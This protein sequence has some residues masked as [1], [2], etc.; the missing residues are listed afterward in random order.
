[1]PRITVWKNNITDEI[2]LAQLSDDPIDGSHEDQLA[3]MTT[4]ESYADYT[5]VDN[6]Y[7]GTFPDNDDVSNWRWNETGI[8]Y[9]PPAPIVP[10]FVTPRQV[11]LLLLQQG[12][13]DEVEAIIAQSDRATQITW[14]FAIQFNRNDPLLQA[15]ANNLNLTS[16]QVDQFFIAASQL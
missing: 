10:E 9:V 11:R 12:L 4:T 1:M 3:F 8:F 14:E 5:C 13:L 2:R 16:E 7:A 6:D 15:L